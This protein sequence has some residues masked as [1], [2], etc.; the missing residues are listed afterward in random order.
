FDLTSDIDEMI[1]SCCIYFKKCN[2]TIEGNSETSFIGKYLLPFFDVVYL[3]N[4]KSNIVLKRPGQISIYQQE[5]E[6]VKIMKEMKGSIDEQIDFG[7]DKPTSFGLLV[8]GYKCSLYMMEIKGDGI[9]ISVMI[10]RFW[11]VE[12]VENA[13]NIPAIVDSLLFVKVLNVANI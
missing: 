8:E 1:K 2:Y 3:K 10:K 9:Y 4:S 11:L 7:V 12:E 13:V 5:S 6:Y